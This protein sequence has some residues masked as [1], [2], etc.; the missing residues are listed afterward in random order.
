MGEAWLARCS[1]QAARRL[2]ISF[3]TSL[4]ETRNLLA[5]TA[6]AATCLNNGEGLPLD[7]LRDVGPH[8]ERL[9]REGTLDVL[10]L[11]DVRAT[12]Q[13]AVRV[14]RFLGSR[15]A[16]TPALSAAATL[17]PSLDAL[18]TELGR[19]VELDGTLRDDASEELGRVRTEIAALRERIVGR[20]EDVIAKQGAL[21]SDNYFTLRDGRYV[22]P[23][24]RDAHDRLPGIV[25]GASSSGASIFVE[26]R[27][28]VA[29]GNRLKV[30]EAEAER[31]QLR[32]LA[33][34]SDR[35]RERLPELLAAAETLNQFD[36]RNAAALL[37]REYRGVA[38]DLS[39]E[40]IAQLKA[41]RHPGLAL[42]GVQV[43]ANDIEIQAGRGLVV[44]GPNAGG[45]TV[46]LKTLGLCALMTR[47]GMLLPAAE[48]SRIGFFDP[49]LTELGD[50]QSTVTNL[51]TFSA[52]VRNLV[53]ILDQTKSGALVLLDEVAT[54]TDPG[55]GGALACALVQTFC[56]RGAALV[57]TTHYE[58]LKALAERDDRLRSASVGFD[59]TRLQP[60]FELLLDVPGASS[61]LTV[62]RR[63]GLPASVIEAAAQF[64]PEQARDFE[65]L[66]QRLRDAAIAARTE[67]A[68]LESERRKVDLERREQEMRSNELQQQSKR[69]LSREA[70]QL[71]NELRAARS[72]LDQARA[73]LR[74][75]DR[76][77]QHLAEAERKIKS[78]A[79]PV[80]VGSDLASA[81]AT[82]QRTPADKPPDVTI[83]ARVY[84][85]RLR[86]DAVVVEGPQKNRV[87][88]AVGAMKLW[89]DLPDLRKAESPAAEPD[90]V[91][92]LREI[93]RTESS[94]LRSADNTL[95]LRGLR[96][97]DALAMLDSFIDRLYS[98]PLRVGFVLHGHGSG[99]LRQAVREHLKAA[100]PYVQTTRPGAPDEGG[101]AITV[102][103]LE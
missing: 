72:E 17:D 75:Q 79:I 86:A 100:P 36:L 69:K 9:A 65:L 26:P 90:N 64:V 30:A 63:Y 50:E 78:A 82:E 43:V 39:D 97:D 58:A 8:L 77:A 96:A 38:P 2:G 70:E 41:A 28:V 56:E 52:H 13:H 18:E 91:V 10:S 22:L 80:T 42:E 84:V 31:E 12:L 19:A 66:V 46:V 68:E 85:P 74:R 4:D 49:I 14:R 57:V 37:A 99:A 61:A 34:L 53:E 88:V 33:A 21:L 60:T 76:D 101:D 51:S 67:R 27:A 94:P 81:L 59:P 11:A 71:M 35:V 7:G 1:G 6:E 5:Q 95:D 20:L 87:L 3:A 103:Y 48:G 47:A 44:S 83:G 98:G 55:E 29:H 73:L 32:I 93:V 62:A 40:P 54:G 24:R 45:K 15:R 16:Q 23:V 102:F 89:V 92:P 25:H